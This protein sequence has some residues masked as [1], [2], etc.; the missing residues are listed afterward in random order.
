MK[1]FR[2]FALLII[3]VMLLG[4]AN[5]QNK[6]ITYDKTAIGP[7]ENYCDGY[8]RPGAEGLGYISV[9]KVST[10][11]VKKT[12][13]A[14][15]DGIVAYDRAEAN[16][17]YIGQINMETASSF[18]GITGQIWG[19][20]IAI[21]EEIKNNTQKPLYSVKQY[22]G[23]DLHVYDAEPLLNAGIALFGTEAD[24][25]FPPAP[26]AHVICANKSITVFRPENGKPNP[27]NNEAYGVWSYI[28]ISI[29]R[30]REKAA[31]L[32]IEDAG[33]W[34]KNDN[35]KEFVKFLDEHTRSVVWSIVAC[36]EDQSVLYDRTYIGYAYVIMDPGYIGTALTAAPYIVLAKN[37]VPKESFDKLKEMTIQEWE[38]AVGF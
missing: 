19:W 2:L 16:D 27:E 38:K 3:S 14:L 32:F 34:T 4:S 23:S 5:G 24:R 18:C 6:T 17:A 8:G 28:A 21:A 36:G 13:D 22:D 1:K 37:A 7:F 35:E 20:D 12:D 26:G 30:D 10:G 31:C 9:L 11:V 15:L 29:A 33:L 25:R